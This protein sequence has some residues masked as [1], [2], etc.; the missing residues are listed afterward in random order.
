MFLSAQKMVEGTP[1]AE[2]QLR[3]RQ[4]DSPQPDRLADSRMDTGERR[5]DVTGSRRIW[6]ARRR[7]TTGGS[8]TMGQN[9]GL[10]GHGGGLAQAV[11]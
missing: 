7:S 1:G 3:F 10:A 8:K 6:R 9:D 2:R 4:P 11:P 5:S